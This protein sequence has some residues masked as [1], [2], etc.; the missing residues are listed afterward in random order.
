M[1]VY[2]HKKTYKTVHGVT[3]PANGVLEQLWGFIAHYQETWL[4]RQQ[5]VEKEMGCL[6]KGYTRL[7]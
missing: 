7:E 6:F 2:V 5:F 4:P 3:Q 1:K